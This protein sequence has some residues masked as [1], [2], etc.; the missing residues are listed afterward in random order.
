MLPTLENLTE[1]Q[2]RKG[3]TFALVEDDFWSYSSSRA[4]RIFNADGYWEAVAYFFWFFC[5]QFIDI[6]NK[7]RQMVRFILNNPQRLV[8][9]KSLEQVLEY[10]FIHLWIMK[11]RQIGMSMLCAIRAVWAAFF[12][13]MNATIYAAEKDE[14]A[15]QLI[16]PYARRALRQIQHK[17]KKGEFPY[18]ELLA[19]NVDKAT[20]FEF[21]DTEFFG[22]MITGRG[23]VRIAK[24]EKGAV[25]EQ[26][27]YMHVTEGS[28]VPHFDAFWDAAWNSLPPPPIFCMSY[29]ESTA[30][31]T[32]PIFFDEF[33]E[34]YDR[35]EETGII[36]DER[37]VFVPAYIHHEYRW[38]ADLVAKTSWS[39]FYKERDDNLY[40]EDEYELVN[41]E[42][43]DP[44]TGEY[45]KLDLAWWLFRRWKIRT[46][47]IKKGQGSFTKRQIVDQ[48]F[49]MLP[50]DAG[51]NATKSVFPPQVVKKRQTLTVEPWMIGDLKFGP[52]NVPEFIPSPSGKLMVWQRPIPYAKFITAWDIAGGVAG[53]YSV[54][55]TW[56]PGAKVLCAG[57]RTNLI[58]PH[59]LPY[60]M[61]ALAMWYNYALLAYEANIYGHFVKPIL[62]GES[63]FPC[64]GTPY[65]NL[66]RRISQPDR[67]YA[68]PKEDVGFWTTDS[69]KIEGQAA[70]SQQF[71][72]FDRF[73]PD[74]NLI[75]KGTDLWW[76]ELFNEARFYE[77]K[78]GSDGQYIEKSPN[79]RHGY[80][81]DILRA[82]E[83][84]L[85]AE[86]QLHHEFHDEVPKTGEP[87]KDDEWLFARIRER[88]ASMDFQD[89]EMFDKMIEVQHELSEYDD[90]IS[91]GGF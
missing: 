6:T 69:S 47:K 44:F 61:I 55:I 41:K 29:V 88:G 12:Y 77:R 51:L 18:P 67:P 10:G 13:A 53:D 54:G 2:I 83:I 9:I 23:R 27:G 37:A 63:T 62:T 50:E 46:Q 36:P 7:E 90:K 76:R 38:P 35:E 86:Q 32:G 3:K 39:Q 4:G 78:V 43:L 5:S 30:L 66:Y 89:Q 28:R 16:F 21:S 58:D 45:K 85:K 57:W 87:T 8:E 71:Q 64:P 48:S 42:W 20:R 17:A 74:G 31:H 33:M 15:M 68:P 26:C 75:Y 22:E 11:P 73:D 91:S 84:A 81:D 60:H 82:L 70:L 79:A 40:G 34:M 19:L 24:A 72:D 25:G 52:D 65:E 49:P 14:Q 1:E 80:N 56:Y 59:D